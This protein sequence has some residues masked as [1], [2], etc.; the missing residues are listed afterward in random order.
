MGL[1]Y[2]RE[3]GNPTRA[4]A[5]SELLAALDLPDAGRETV[6]NFVH[7]DHTDQPH[8][9]EVLAELADAVGK[10]WVRA[11]SHRW[12]EPREVAPLWVARAGGS[13]IV[14]LRN[15]DGET[16]W[17]EADRITA[18]EVLARAQSPAD[19]ADVPPT[20]H[21]GGGLM[22]TVELG[23]DAVWAVDGYGATVPDDRPTQGALRVTKEVA[24]VAAGARMALRLAGVA[25]VVDPPEVVAEAQ[26]R[27][28][29]LLERM[30]QA[31]G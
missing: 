30:E 3:T 29:A 5:M 11:H 19:A 28:A 10:V 17:V 8:L 6:A 22:L 13:A 27:A 12:D 31:A 20:S 14:C 21:R 16:F 26:R 25:R 1:D 18:V 2:I 9:P 15:D 23:P 4:Q 7:L 24:G